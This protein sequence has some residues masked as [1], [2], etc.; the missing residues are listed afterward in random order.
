MDDVADSWE[1][2]SERIRD[3]RIE[4]QQLNAD[5]NVKEYFLSVADAYGDELRAGVLRGEI[6]E[7]NEKIADTQADASTELKGN[8]KAAR[9]NRSTL[10]G[11]VENYQD[12]ITALA[13]SGADQATLN[14]AVNKSRA[15]F[16]A[17]AQAL[18]F[19][20]AQL[21]PYIASFG[22]MRTAINN[23]PRNITV[24]ANT[25]PALQALN[26][27]VAAA[28]RAGGSAGAGFAS[29]MNAGLAKTG[30]GIALQNQIMEWQRLMGVYISAGNFD[31]ARY[32][33]QSIKLYSDKLRLGNYY[34]GG[35]TGAGGKYEP[36]GIVHKGEY[37]V[38]KQHVDQSTGLPKPSF[39]G[40]TGSQMPASRGAS[41]AGGGLVGGS[42]GI[43]V[44]LSPQ[45]RNL[46]RQVGASGDIVVAVDS[47]EI[48]RASNKGN[49]K[50]R[51][52]G[53]F[54]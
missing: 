20:N 19:S 22:D 39:M 36:A 44:S 24:T 45:D 53:G 13:E 17:Q 50:I 16:I 3:A 29:G 27:F 41:Y 51:G 38:P 42:G 46:L 15:E 11:L 21:Q 26:E 5:K 2:L 40:A 14:A 52:F 4:I 28:T 10:T 1:T 54:G 7:I 30:R 35:Y 25:N 8:S 23:V 33:G 6:A 43:M 49:E 18:G 31:G 47:T 12:Y 34:S 48:A 32:L 37:V 9:Q